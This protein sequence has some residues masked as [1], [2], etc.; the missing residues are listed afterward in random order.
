MWRVSCFQPLCRVA[1]IMCRGCVVVVLVLCCV[2]VGRGDPRA[3]E[4]AAETSKPSSNLMTRDLDGIAGKEAVMLTVE[5]GP[6]AKS[7]PHR[8]DANVFVYVLEGS[9]VMQVEGQ[10]PVTLQPGQTFYEGPKDVHLV[11]ANASAS[12]P[13]KILVFIVKD[14]GAP[15]TRPVT[16]TQH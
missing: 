11:S 14:K 3:A 16:G 2:L 10:E 1:V 7:P 12:R 4:R 15:V 9:I 6:G 13:A 5:Y 8:H